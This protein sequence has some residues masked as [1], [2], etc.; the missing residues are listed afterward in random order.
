VM[1]FCFPLSRGPP[2]VSFR[3]T[4]KFR[5]LRRVMPAGFLFPR[6][7]RPS[8]WINPLG[9]VSSDRLLLSFAAKPARQIDDDY[10]QQD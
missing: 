5:R 3:F 2:T 9:L 1:C 7:P 6:A 4:S 10:D 8:P